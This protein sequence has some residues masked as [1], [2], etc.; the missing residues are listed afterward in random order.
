MKPSFF[1]FILLF[2]LL[3]MLNPTHT[4]AHNQNHAMIGPHFFVK[5]TDVPNAHD[6]K[7]Q[8]N[9]KEQ[10]SLDTPSDDDTFSDDEDENDNDMEDIPD[11]FYDYQEENL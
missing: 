11:D 8:P 3:Y 2:I 10:K 7:A 5:I 4:T 1:M 9:D 6:K